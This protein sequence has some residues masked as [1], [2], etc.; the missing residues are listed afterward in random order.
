[1]SI[2]EESGELFFQ[3]PKLSGMNDQQQHRTLFEFMSLYGVVAD[4]L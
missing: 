3:N 2:I 4:Y 1:M